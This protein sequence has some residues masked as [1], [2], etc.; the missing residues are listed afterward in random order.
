LYECDSA[1]PSPRC[2]PRDASQEEE[3]HGFLDVSEDS[4]NGENA[5]NILEE[6]LQRHNWTKKDLNR[7]ENRTVATELIAILVRKNG[8]SGREVAEI[9]GINREKVRRILVSLVSR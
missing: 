5:Q 6:F 8:I 7:S 4:G 3:T 9:T 1:E 2:S